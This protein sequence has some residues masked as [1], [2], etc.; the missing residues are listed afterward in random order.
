VF[1][2][3]QEQGFWAAVGRVLSD[4]SER[5]SV[6]LMLRKVTGPPTLLMAARVGAPVPVWGSRWMAGLL[7]DDVCGKSRS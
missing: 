7:L 1:H 2:R 4:Y 6:S 3:G 5:E